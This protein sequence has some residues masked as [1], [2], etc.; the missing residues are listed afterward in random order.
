VFVRAEE[1]PGVRRAGFEFYSRARFIAVT[2]DLF[3]LP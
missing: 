3:T 2:G 1:A